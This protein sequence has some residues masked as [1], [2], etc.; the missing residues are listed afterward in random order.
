LARGRYASFLF[1]SAASNAF[2]ICLDRCVSAKCV[3]DAHVQAITARIAAVSRVPYE[4]SE[5]LQVLHYEVR[6]ERASE[7]ARE[8]GVAGGGGGFER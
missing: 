1:S 7:R 8:R 6:S 2:V 3:S 4:N 5:Y